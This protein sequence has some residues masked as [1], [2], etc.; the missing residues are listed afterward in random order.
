MK[1]GSKEW[2]EWCE[3]YE[4]VKKDILM[5]TEDMKLSKFMIMRLKGLSQGV[6]INSKGKLT[7]LANYSFKT[8]LMTFK[9]KKSDIINYINRNEGI[10]NGERHKFNGIMTIIENSINDTVIILGRAKKSKEKSENIE[11]DTQ[12]SKYSGSSY[13]SKNKKKI[14]NDR[15]KDLW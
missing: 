14:K 12:E 9:L 6:F 4:Y 3:L 5:Y 1:K 2:E 7:P 8:I 13:K 15:L 10:F 11:L